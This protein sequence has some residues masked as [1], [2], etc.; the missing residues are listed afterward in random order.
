[1]ASIYKRNESNVLWMRF[2]Y[3][4]KT[5]RETTGQSN[6]QKAEAVMRKRIK[7]IQGSGS[8][9]DLFK[10]LLVAIDKLPVNEQDELRREFASKLRSST[11]VN[12]SLADAFAEYSTKPRKHDPSPATL[13]RYQGDWKRFT[14]WMATNHATIEYMHQVEHVHAMRYMTARWK[15]GI[16]SRTFNK[17]L[18]LYKGIF[19]TLWLEA[20]LQSNPFDHIEKQGLKTT[21]KKNLEPGQIEALLAVAAASAC[22]LAIRSASILVKVVIC[23]R[24]LSK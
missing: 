23:W 5:Y 11:V 4:G 16:T 7:E 9:N 15:E 10:R 18:T 12:L 1:M 8:A 17:D 3:K 22:L 14:D 24:N 13:K 2:A 19:K 21:G 6:K 20:G